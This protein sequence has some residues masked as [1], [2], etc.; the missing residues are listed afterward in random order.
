MSA[1]N[2]AQASTDDLLERFRGIARRIGTVWGRP[3]EEMM[4]K[5]PERD[6]LFRQ[7]HAIADELTARNP[8]AKIRAMW[9]D[10]DVDVR[11]MAA[12]RFHALDPEWAEASFSGL[13]E[14]PRLTM[15][16]TLELRRR[17]LERLPRRPPLQRMPLDELIAYFEDM[18]TREYGA[19]FVADPNSS[20]WD[21]ELRNRLLDEIW[22]IE[23][24]IASRDALARLL[25]FLD[26][27]YDSVRLWAADACLPVAP[28]RALPVLEA[29]AATSS[30]YT[31]DYARDILRRWRRENGDAEEED[32][33]AE[34]AEE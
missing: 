19:K 30:D 16:E 29:L 14:N 26:H 4:R 1:D 20:L 28:E 12:M 22:D 15:R 10:D 5:S 21:V 6:E 8:I 2:Y 25:P 33:G 31:R 34:E 3:L 32:G 18:A 17:A 7:Y 9:D 24:E 27:P 11:A 13:C 23:K